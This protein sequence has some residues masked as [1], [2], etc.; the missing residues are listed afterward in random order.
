[1]PRKSLSHLFPL[2]SPPNWPPLLSLK[3][4]IPWWP[5]LIIT[6]GELSQHGCGGEPLQSPAKARWKT[7]PA[8]A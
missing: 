2:Q 5:L 3:A 6:P 1:M 4:P 7:G 8:P